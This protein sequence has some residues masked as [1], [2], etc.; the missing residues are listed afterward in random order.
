MRPL[1]VFKYRRFN[2]QQFLFEQRNASFPCALL[3]QLE[4]G[5]LGND[6]LLDDRPSCLNRTVKLTAVGGNEVCLTELA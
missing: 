1:E 3:L 5:E 4:L 6:S 2:L